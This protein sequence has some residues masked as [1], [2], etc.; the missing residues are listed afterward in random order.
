MSVLALMLALV[1]FQGCTRVGPGHKAVKVSLA[2]SDRGIDKSALTTGWVFY[3]PL[4]TKIVSVPVSFQNATWTKNLDEG[5]PR[6]EEFTFNANGGTKMTVD[7]S[8]AYRLEGDSLPK[9]YN[10]FLS[11]PDYSDDLAEFTNVYVHNIARNVINVV[12]ARYTFEE[13]YDKKQEIMDSV[14]TAINKKLAYVGFSVGQL[15]VIGDFGAPAELVASLNAKNAAIQN[16]I[17]SQNEV[18]QATA[19]AEKLVAKTTGEANSAIEKARGDAEANKILASS[20]TPQLIQWKQLEMV[21]QQLDK[22]NGNLPQV[23]TNG[24]GLI[25]SLPQMTPTYQASG[26]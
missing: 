7:L 19:E 18:A 25:L 15:G 14:E 22:W 24:N 10:E 8:L 12:C 21:K 17:R 20:I 2:G 16:A 11:N 3:N 6:N 4:G 5:N 13:M 26:K 23:T 9:F 1:V